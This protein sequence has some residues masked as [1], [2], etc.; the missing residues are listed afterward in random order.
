MVAT[1]AMNLIPG[2]CGHWDCFLAGLDTSEAGQEQPPAPISGRLAACSLIR[3]HEGWL[4]PSLRPFCVGVR[5]VTG[6]AFACL[7]LP[8]A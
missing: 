8:P 6:L 7:P 4:A 5:C 2:G 1:D 3:R